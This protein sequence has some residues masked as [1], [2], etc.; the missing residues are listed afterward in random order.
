MMITL[1]ILTFIVIG[2]SGYRYYSA[3]DARKA[4]KEAT[5]ARIALLLNE[6]WR[7]YGDANDNRYTTYDPVTQLAG[8]GL[9]I[10]ASTSGGPSTPSGFTAIGNSYQFTIDNATYFVTLAYN[11]D[12]SAVM[13][14]I[15]DQQNAGHKRVALTTIVAWP[16]TTSKTTYSDSVADYRNFVLTTYIEV[17]MGE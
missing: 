9:V 15:T 10:S 7:G 12:A 11:P 17:G 8:T 14:Q 13:G 5:A 16:I 6:G 4:S 1:L 3:V 2:T